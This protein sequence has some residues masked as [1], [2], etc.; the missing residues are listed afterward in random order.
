MLNHASLDL[1][2]LADDQCEIGVRKN[3]NSL[4][5][6]LCWF[7]GLS[8]SIREGASIKALKAKPRQNE[9]EPLV[10]YQGFAFLDLRLDCKLLKRNGRP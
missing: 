7:A 6:T 5:E 8:P 1:C 10:R 2:K 4:M 9:I 3:V